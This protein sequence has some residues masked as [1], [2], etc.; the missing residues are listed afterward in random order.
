MNAGLTVVEWEAD[1]GL[2]AIASLF[3]STMK[4]QPLSIKTQ[5]ADQRA[6][7]A[8]GIFSLIPLKK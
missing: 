4:C 5:L 6:G 8:S 3:S 2:C 7:R 1:D